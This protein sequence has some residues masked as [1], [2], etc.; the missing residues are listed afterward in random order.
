[1]ITVVPPLE[2]LRNTPVLRSEMPAGFDRAKV[3]VLSP[4]ARYHTLGAVRVDFTRPGTS[5]QVAV[6]GRI[7]IS[8]AGATRAQVSALIS[9][10]LEHLRRSEH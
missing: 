8:A 7:V 10:G 5:E 1:M 9:F 4:D 6:V 3:S 2:R